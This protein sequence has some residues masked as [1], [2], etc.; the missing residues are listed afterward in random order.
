MSHKTATVFGRRA[1]ESTR[2]FIEHEG[3][4]SLEGVLSAKEIKRLRSGG[5]SEPNFKRALSEVYDKVE[6][7]FYLGQAEVSSNIYGVPWRADFVLFDPERQAYGLCIECKTQTCAGSVDEKYVFVEHSLRNVAQINGCRVLFLLQG[8]GARDCVIDYLRGRSQSD[9][10][11]DFA[12]DT[13]E[14]RGVLR[15]TKTKKVPLQKTLFQ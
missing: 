15:G 1:E 3:Y 13:F 14:L 10:W 5:L 4:I 12:T 7:P 11:F 8:G 6:A 2:E 9:E